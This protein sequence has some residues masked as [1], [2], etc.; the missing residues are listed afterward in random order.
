[1]TAYGIL[2]GKNLVSLFSD[3]LK[4]VQIFFFKL[5][6]CVWRF[7]R[8][9]NRKL[10]GI[11]DMWARLLLYCGRRG[12]KTLFWLAKT[13]SLSFL[14]G[15]KVFKYF[16]SNYWR[17]YGDFREEITENCMGLPICELGYFCTV[18]EEDGKLYSDWPK[19]CLSLFWF[20]KKCCNIYFRL[21]TSVR[22]LGRWL[23]TRTPRMPTSRR[24]GE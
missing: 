19:P 15:W 1:M 7:S 3:W 8:G 22:L 2:I 12:R 5:L 20:A 24:W 13:L 9:D 6:T 23:T 14:I 4:S 10:Y 18:V 11:T 17:V 21:P 16:F